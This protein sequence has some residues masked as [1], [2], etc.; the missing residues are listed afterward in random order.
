[1]GEKKEL[2]PDLWS[3][4]IVSINILMFSSA[5]FYGFYKRKYLAGI[6]VLFMSIWFI[7]GFIKIYKIYTRK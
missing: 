1:M 3:F 6:V 5:T 7:R 2:K 4:I